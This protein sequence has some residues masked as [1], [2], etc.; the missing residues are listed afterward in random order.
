MATIKHTKTNALADWTQLQL[1]T[2]IAGGAAPLPP[3][4]TTV[5]QVVQPTDWN[6]DHTFDASFVE[7]NDT[8]NSYTGQAGKFLQ[9]KGA[10]DGLQ[11]VSSSSSVARVGLRAVPPGA[12][13]APF[14]ALNVHMEVN[15]PATAAAP[16][17][18]PIRLSIK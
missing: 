11:F 15:C 17:P 7:L 5:S 14:E 3:S 10:E 9:V 18:E 4:G 8:P 13:P 2:V 6:A 1:D 16:A 12:A